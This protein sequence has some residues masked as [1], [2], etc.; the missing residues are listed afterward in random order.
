MGPRSLALPPAA[1]PA[2]AQEAA[3]PAGPDAEAAEA[4]LPAEAPAAPAAKAP[5]IERIQFRGNRKVEDDAIRVNLVSRAGAD[6]D[7]DKLREDVRALWKMG[8]FEDV[9]VEAEPGGEPGTVVLTFAVVE[10][11]SIRKILVAGNQEVGL[12]KINEVLDLKRD[13]ILD[14]TK[15]KRNV[16]KVRELYVGKGYYLA[17]VD[18]QVRPVNE[19]EVDVWFMVDENS[20][21]Q[22]RRVSFIG[23]RSVTEEE[24]RS[25]MATKEG[26]F[27]SF[28]TDSGTYQ[29]E[30]FERDLTLIT[31]YYYDKGY[32]NVKIGA[33]QI[34]LSR[35]KRYMYIAVPI[36][37]G[38][39]FAIGKLDFKGDLFGTKADYH[40]R[41][42]TKERATFNRT[43]LG[44]DIIRLNDLYKDRGFAYVN[45]TP[46]TAIDI[47]KR[48]IGI[49]FEIEK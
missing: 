17:S 1:A 10:K 7:S 43:R 47:D 4:A 42:A 8:F 20:K 12:D 25:V 46:L 45:V 19:S 16:E 6:L 27:F 2:A 30:T 24:L 33:P 3:A 31:A 5:R 35:D 41:L 11:P 32:V 36:D 44:Q 15:V 40:A 49:T 26:G 38:P 13:A 23:N 29:E 34:T 21:V 39:V 22:I 9:K 18:Y 48:T 14:V 28:L 37:E